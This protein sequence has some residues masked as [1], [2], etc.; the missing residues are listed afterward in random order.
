[1]KRQVYHQCLFNIFNDVQSLSLHPF[2]R[3]GVMMLVYGGINAVDEETR[4]L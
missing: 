3:E 1:M 2:I 4:H